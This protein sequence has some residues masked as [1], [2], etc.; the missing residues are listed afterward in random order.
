MMAKRRARKARVLDKH[1]SQ[2]RGGFSRNGR[3]GPHHG[4]TR[5]HGAACC[6]RSSWCGGR[7][8]KRS[9]WCVRGKGGAWG[10]RFDGPAPPVAGKKFGRPVRN[11]VGKTNRGVAKSVG[12]FKKIRHGG[13][14]CNRV[15]HHQRRK[16]FRKYKAKKAAKMIAKKANMSFKGAQKIGKTNRGGG[17]KS[18]GKI[19][20]QVVNGV[21]PLNRHHAPCRQNPPASW[22]SRPLKMAQRL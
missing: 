4:G 22:C 13:H 6:S 2:A 11:N 7:K 5:C 16:C 21:H 1:K 15:P 20:F 3:C 10:G 18:L 9:A 8:G 17:M 14:P 12:G 19:N